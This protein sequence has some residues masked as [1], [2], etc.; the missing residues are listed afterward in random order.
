MGMMPS[1][2]RAEAMSMDLER[3][4]RATLHSRVERWECDFNDHWNVRFYVR[5]L[6]TP[7]LG[8]SP[9]SHRGE[10]VVGLGGFWETRRSNFDSRVE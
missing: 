6:V 10:K 1:D 2:R 8:V 4:G 5:S 7:K 9:K 3:L